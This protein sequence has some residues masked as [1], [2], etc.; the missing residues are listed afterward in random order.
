MRQD[1]EQAHRRC[2]TFSASRPSAQGQGP[3]PSVSE[4]SRKMFP[5]VLVCSS[6]VLRD[7]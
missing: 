4:L 7:Q 6:N 5:N 2:A 1:V 3:E